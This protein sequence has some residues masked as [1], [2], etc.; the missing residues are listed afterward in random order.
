M[1]PQPRSRLKDGRA[2]EYKTEQAVD[3]ETGAIVAVTTHG[4]AKADTESILESLPE[5]RQ[6]LAEQVLEKAVKI[7][8]VQEVVADKGYHSQC[9]AAN[10]EGVGIEKLHRRAGAR[11]AELA[12]ATSRESGGVRQSKTD[13]SRT[14][15]AIAGPAWRAAG[16]DFA[17]QF[18][19]GGMERLYVRG[20]HNVHKKLLLQAAACNLALLMRAL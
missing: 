19:T 8:G 11:C 4:G 13:S 5:A 12:S 7:E 9:R 3:M 2:L 14:G 10:C 18:D 1:T 15:E 6:A 20:R 17:H 16:A